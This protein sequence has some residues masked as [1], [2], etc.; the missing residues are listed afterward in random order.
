MNVMKCPRRFFVEKL[1]PLILTNQTKSQGETAGISKT[2]DLIHNFSDLLVMSREEQKEMQVLR[3]SI[4]AQRRQ[5]GD[6]MSK[7]LEN[8]TLK[9]RFS[10]PA[11]IRGKTLQISEGNT[12]AP[13]PGPSKT[14]S[15]KST[16]KPA[17]TARKGTKRA[18]PTE[19]KQKI[20]HDSTAN[21]Q[22]VERMKQVK[23]RGSVSVVAFHPIESSVAIIGMFD[24]TFRL[25][26]IKD[27]TA[28]ETGNVGS[29]GNIHSTS[30]ITKMKWDPSGSCTCISGTKPAIFVLTWIKSKY[31]LIF[32]LHNVRQIGS[33]SGKYDKRVILN[34]FVFLP[35]TLKSE[36]HLICASDLHLRNEGKQ[37]I[38]TKKFCV[39]P[40]PRFVE[41]SDCPCVSLAALSRNYGGKQSYVVYGITMVGDVVMWNPLELGSRK[42]VFKGCF[43]EVI[44]S[45][46]ANVSRW[47]LIKLSPGVNLYPD[48]EG[49]TGSTNGVKGFR[50]DKK[51]EQVHIFAS[52][53]LF[54]DNGAY[55]M[56]D[57]VVNITRK[58]SF[59]RAS[60][61]HKYPWNMVNMV[62]FEPPDYVLADKKMYVV[63]KKDMKMW[64]LGSDAHTSIPF[65]PS[66]KN[67][68]LDETAPRVHRVAVNSSN[69]LMCV[70]KGDNICLYR[71]IG[72]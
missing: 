60:P 72:S 17:R 4:R 47:D 27:G 69:G 26:D 54:T 50:G 3:G 5:L 38:S 1:K 7:L 30:V 65:W 9:L 13:R 51:F 56:V 35:N 57:V 16:H 67:S 6:K 41:C 42:S 52:V 66:K 31:P 25:V 61:V 28:F 15:F 70:S 23:V 68:K 58:G 11:G 44:E 53:Q 33:N 8:N 12:P 2:Y 49:A 46:L 59:R 45:A 37:V 32:K 18:Y 19:K 63:G 34:D 39:H 36:Y 20:S 64:T 43:S 62:T 48:K 24:G 40:E 21:R 29:E 71:I 10:H 14:T 22:V 55:N